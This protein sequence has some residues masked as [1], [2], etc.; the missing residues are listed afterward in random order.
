MRNDDVDQRPELGVIGTEI[1]ECDQDGADEV[2]RDERGM[3]TAEYAVGTIAAV[4]FA[5]VLISVL[6][7]KDILDLLLKLIIFLLKLFWPQLGA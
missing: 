3:T 5:G 4:S 7:N 2:S 6:T 1:A